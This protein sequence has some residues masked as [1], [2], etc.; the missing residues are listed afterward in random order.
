MP[1]PRRVRTLGRA[2]RRLIDQCLLHHFDALAEK[3]GDPHKR[4]H[5]DRH[6][7]DPAALLHLHRPPQRGADIWQVGTVLLDHRTRIAPQLRLGRDDDPQVVLGMR[8][9]ESVSLGQGI[10]LFQREVADDL[11]HGEAGLSVER[12]LGPKETLVH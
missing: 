6:A 2:E 8:P 10:Q 7:G 3:P 1:S 5:G 4:P 12:V 9:P 11:Q